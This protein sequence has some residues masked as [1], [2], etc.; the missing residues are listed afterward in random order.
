MIPDEPGRVRLRKTDAESGEP[1]PGVEFGLYVSGSSEP[2]CL[3]ETDEDG[4]ALSGYLADGI[5]E[6]REVRVPEGLYPGYADAD[7][8]GSG[9]ADRGRAAGPICQ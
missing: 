4:Y 7:C 1:L 6:I 9:R 5:Y 2:V 3:L 8:D